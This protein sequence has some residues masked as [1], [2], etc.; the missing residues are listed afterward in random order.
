M[1]K[2]LG[3]SLSEML[4]IIAIMGIVTLVTVPALLQLMPQYRIRSAASEAAGTIRMVRQRAIATRTPWRISYDPAD[5]RYRLW[6]LSSP[7]ADLSVGAN[8]Q[9]VRRDGRT[10]DARNEDWYSS[11]AIDL[12]G[13][14]TTFNDVTC[15][16][17][18]DLDLIF[19]R[20]GTV[21]DDPPCGGTSADELTFAPNPSI[22]FSVD[23]NLVRFNRYYI[24]VSKEGLVAV[25]PAK[26]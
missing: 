17:D 9:P 19:L 20:D 7:H 21:A 10:I 23:S 6:T 24:S 15:P 26:E 14:S 3:Y 12:Q 2:Q 13:G 5:N 18:G 25:R 22:L 1:R 16:S 11:S 8:W 4:V